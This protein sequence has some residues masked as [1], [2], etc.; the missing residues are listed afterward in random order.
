M[1]TQELY[2]AIDII[3]SGDKQTAIPILA[4]IL[5]ENPRNEKAWVYLYYCIEDKEKQLECLKQAIF[6]N[7]KNEN[8]RNLI[9]KLDPD[10]N[11]K[12]KASEKGIEI[13]PINSE[14]IKTAEDTPIEKDDNQTLHNPSPNVELDK[15]NKAAKKHDLTIG[16]EKDQKICDSNS[17]KK[18]VFSEEI[19]TKKKVN[20]QKKNEKHEDNFSYGFR[21]GI[22]QSSRLETGIFGKTIIVDGLKIPANGGPPC[23]SGGNVVSEE[24]CETCEY[25]SSK[26][27][28]LRYDSYLFEELNQFLAI[29]EEQQVQQIK[30]SK[31]ISKIIHYELKAHGRPLHYSMIS[32][33]ITSR[34]PKLHLSE[35]GIR[36]FMDWH[37][38][39][40][41]RV[42]EGIYKAK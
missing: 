39:L 30:R 26:E 37:R 24:D 12:I 20:K 9:N 35:K 16:T 42:E 33:I 36:R 34:Y 17:S 10:Y 11:K 41:E 8:V 14:Q 29:R 18:K 13:I 22:N 2:R 27:C 15:F 25:F 6:I 31:A 5:V 40:F 3:E 28:L 32:K 21:E 1:F 19:H 4:K 38:D 23:L 7:P